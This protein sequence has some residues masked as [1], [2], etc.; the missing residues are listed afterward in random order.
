MS[1]WLSAAADAVRRDPAAIFTLFPVAGRHCGQGSAGADAAR[2]EL[3]TSLPLSGPALA[4]TLLRLYRHGD[5]AERRAVLLALPAV[6]VGPAALP[7]VEDALRT[8]DSRLVLAAV[9]RYATLHLSPAAFRQA[10]LKCVFMG[11][12][13]A[14]VDGLPE[15]ADAELAAMLARFAEERVAAGRAVPADIRPITEELV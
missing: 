8:N 13:L 7:I 4:E 10:V 11:L 1:A 6:A 14:A 15:R 9:G 12:P 5:A 2:V 3:I